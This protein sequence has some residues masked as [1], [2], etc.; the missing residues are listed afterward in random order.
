MKWKEIARK[1]PRR[2]SVEIKHA[3]H[4]QA[5]LECMPRCYH[6][7]LNISM[8]H[9]SQRIRIYKRRLKASRVNLNVMHQ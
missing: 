9:D 5:G 4:G 3:A 7:H 1:G 2:V 6:V 8:I